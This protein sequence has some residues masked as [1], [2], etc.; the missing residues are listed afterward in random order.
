MAPAPSRDRGRVPILERSPGAGVSPEGGHRRRPRDRRDR[1]GD[2]L[3]QPRTGFGHRGRVH[4]QS[5]DRGAVA[6]RRHPVRCPGRGRGGRDPSDRADRRP[7]RTDAVG[8]RGASGVGDAPGAALR[9]PVRHRVH[10]RRRPAVAAPGP[11]REA[12]P[13]GRPADRGR[14]G[15]GRVVPGVARGRRRAGRAAAR[16]STDDRH[17]PQQLPPAAGDRP[18]RLA[19]DR[20]R[21]DRHEPGG[22]HGSRGRRTVA[23]PR[24]GRDVTR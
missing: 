18:A 16:R 12:E 8:G 20:E 3:R 17:E 23:D 24:P 7:R 5:G 15:R 1:P 14:H 2:G 4:A 10:D 6:V 19:R 21:P 11:G 9:R 22:G 13:A